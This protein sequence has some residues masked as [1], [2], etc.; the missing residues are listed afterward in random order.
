[1][2]LGVS[3]DNVDFHESFCTKKGLNFK[4]LPDSNHAVVENYGSIMEHN[5]MTLAAR[6]FLIEPMG[7]IRKV[8]S[9]SVRRVT[10]RKC[11]LICN[12]CS[13]QSEALLNPGFASSDWRYTVSGTPDVL[14]LVRKLPRSQGITGQLSSWGWNLHGATR[15]VV[16]SSKSETGLQAE[17]E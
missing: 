15:G 3:V 7:I 13:P 9:R 1:V 17:P 5:G 11:W 6:N 10:A 14:R 4:V 2:I 8:Y 12:S 16:N